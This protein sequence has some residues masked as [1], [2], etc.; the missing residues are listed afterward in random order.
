MNPAQLMAVAFQSFADN[1]SKIGTLNIAPE[2]MQDLMTA[3]KA[4]G[5]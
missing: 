2:V 5:W 1:A 4:E 3:T